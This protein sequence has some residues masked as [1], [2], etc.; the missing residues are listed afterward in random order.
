MQY[1]ADGSW[2]APIHAPGHRGSRPNV[3]PGL[4]GNAREVTPG[5]ITV[6][7]ACPQIP[8]VFQKVCYSELSFVYIRLLRLRLRR[9][10]RLRLRLRLRLRRR[11]RRLQR[12]CSGRSD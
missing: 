10:W 7:P 3:A 9:L 4:E 8:S 11:R 5:T 12:Q 1:P 2:A 6:T